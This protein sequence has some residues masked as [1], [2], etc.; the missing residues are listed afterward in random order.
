VIKAGQSAR[1]KTGQWLV[2]QPSDHHRAANNGNKRV[3]IFLAN[4][5][6]KNAN[7]SKPLP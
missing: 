5:L 7:P 2:E 3:V 1:I 6:L 4:L